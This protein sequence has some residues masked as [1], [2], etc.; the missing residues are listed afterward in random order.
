[1]ATKVT[2]SEFATKVLEGEGTYLVDFYADWCGPCKMIAPSLE[3]LATEYAGRLTLVKVD[4]DQAQTL[5]GA[6]GIQSIPTLIFFRDGKPAHKIVG[7]LPKPAIKAQIEKVLA[8][9]VA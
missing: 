8:T 7:A 1:V 4:V 3:E 9:P 2:E 6:Y 5:A